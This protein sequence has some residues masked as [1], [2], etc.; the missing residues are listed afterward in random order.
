MKYSGKYLWHLWSFADPCDFS[1]FTASAILIGHYHLVIT[2][3]IPLGKVFS[4][5]WC[6]NMSLT[7]LKLIFHFF[8]MKQVKFLPCISRVYLKIRY[9]KFYYKWK[10][11]T[12]FHLIKLSQVYKI[13]KCQKQVFLNLQNIQIDLLNQKSKFHIKTKYYTIIKIQNCH[14]SIIKRQFTPSLVQYLVKMQINQLKTAH[15]RY[16]KYFTMFKYTCILHR[17][18]TYFTIKYLKILFQGMKILQN[19]QIG[20]IV[21]KRYMRRIKRVSH[22]VSIL[23]MSP[24]VIRSSI[25]HSIIEKCK[26]IQICQHR[27]RY[28]LVKFVQHMNY[29]A[30]YTHYLNDKSSRHPSKSIKLNLFPHLFHQ[31]HFISKYSTV[32]SGSIQIFIHFIHYYEYIVFLSIKSRQMQLQHVKLIICNL[33]VICKNHVHSRKLIRSL[34]I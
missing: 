32:R 5:N 28:K 25:K 22:N 7:L 18:E 21:K 20:L 15:F 1:L 2:F 17:I 26:E 12:P 8:H 24:V 29:L 10:S 19:I 23:N 31:I 30:F 13:I 27:V 14:S 9:L 3:L 4:C 33:A 11:I 16:L 34:N 6:S